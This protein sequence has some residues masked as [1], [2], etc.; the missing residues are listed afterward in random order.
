MLLDVVDNVLPPLSPP[1]GGG[2]GV[3]A[4]LASLVAGDP[5][6]GEYRVCGGIVSRFARKSAGANIEFWKC[7]KAAFRLLG[8]C[9]FV[10][11]K[12]SLFQ[13]ALNF[14]LLKALLREV[15]KIISVSIPT[16]FVTKCQ[17]F[18]QNVNILSQNVKICHEM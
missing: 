1:V 9:S 13:H 11:F 4:H 8:L 12:I 2:H 18:S 10:T 7:A 16:N 14:F 3:Q 15:L 17:H 6:V 5:V